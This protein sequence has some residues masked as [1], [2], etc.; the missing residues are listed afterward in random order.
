MTKHLKGHLIRELVAHFG[1]DTRRIEHALDV[2]TH[3]RA[4]LEDTPDADEDI[5]V[6]AAV[7]HD[8]GIKR[9]EAIHGCNN[10]KMQEE[11]G[12]EEARPALEHCGFPE[13][14]IEAVLHIIAHHH[15]HHENP[16]LEFLI[17]TEADCLVNVYDTPD[18]LKD[19][20]KTRRFIER[21]FATDAGQK[22]ARKIL[23]GGEELFQ[24]MG[25]VYKVLVSSGSRRDKEADFLLKAA[26]DH[27]ASG[28]DDFQM[29]DLACGTGFH[30]RL[31]AEKGYRILALDYSESLLDE[32]RKQTAS[33]LKIEY[34]YADL[35]EPLP[36]D[37]GGDYY[38][39]LGNT[40]SVFENTHAVENVLKHVIDAARNGARLLC[41]IVNYEPLLK[42]GEAQH[43][44]RRGMVDDQDTVLTKTL[45]PLVDRDEILIQLAASR[46]DDKGAWSSFARPSL[47]QP[48][49]PEALAR[50]ADA[51]GW[52]LRG[53]WGD[54]QGHPFNENKSSDFVLLLEKE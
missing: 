50:S 9:A 2:L 8:F 39:L 5:V 25:K 24:E 40:L 44:T 4:L 37:A 11:Y 17:L 43:L 6:A 12:P 54:L 1:S 30:S 13:D 45:M 15:S 32:A 29:V 33:D 49:A 28:S 27:P 3:A 22:R 18:I 10:G 46:R 53:Q 42:S 19:P 36:P 38:L 51:A 20:E 21:N 26:A 34:H 31:L 14:K 48:L 52:I 41:Q 47:L 35:R 16:T 23:G 7:T